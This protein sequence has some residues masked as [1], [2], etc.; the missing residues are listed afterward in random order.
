MSRPG[1]PTSV[2]VRSVAKAANVSV[3]T[4]SRVFANSAAVTEE[5]RK[6]V[7]E[8]ADELGYRPNPVAKSLA[9]GRSLQVGV[10]VPDL[11]NPFFNEIIRGIDRAASADS[12]T[13]L[14]G[15]SLTIAE[16]EA[17]LTE[18]L[19]L[20]VDALIL[21]GPRRTITELNALAG[22]RKPV[23]TVLGPP[24]VRLRNVTVDNYGGMVQVY[25]HLFA[26]GHRR[27]VYLAGPANSS[28]NTLR[29]S[30][31]L[32]AESLGMEVAV[33]EAGSDIEAGVKAFDAVLE[34]DP[35]AIVA[36]N[37]LLAIGALSR[38]RELGISPPDDLSLTGFD[39]I[40]YTQFIHPRLTT[41][42]TPKFELGR[43]AWQ[44]V[45]RHLRGEAA[46][47]LEPLPAELVVG[48]STSGARDEA[49]R[50]VYSEK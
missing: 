28:Q 37:D 19:L 25:D 16:D 36:Y 11:G 46:V 27:V 13:M 31:I 4:V 20:S 44:E 40:K 47:L 6:R 29:R 1:S 43:L 34:H 42:R 7:L 5:T 49:A 22:S 26:L 2:T 35:T 23:V 41:V 10:I 24:G 33:V 45:Q 30:A 21:V 32:H 8:A 48:D 14:L 9:T 18:Q 38:M 50:A 17:R 39:D 12:F 3:A 15:D